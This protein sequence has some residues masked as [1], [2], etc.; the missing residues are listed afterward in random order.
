[1]PKI[2]VFGGMT[3]IH[4]SGLLPAVASELPVEVAEREDGT[5]TEVA[6]ADDETGAP[7]EE[8]GTGDP[9]PDGEDNS[10][11]EDGKDD[12]GPLFDPGAYTVAEVKT[13]LEGLSDDERDR[14][15]AAERAGKDRA[16]ITG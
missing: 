9:P 15:I 13:R 6:P 5:V 1:M 12:D 14:V 2:S 7:A 3:D 8:E 4:A 10:S 11:G 16:G